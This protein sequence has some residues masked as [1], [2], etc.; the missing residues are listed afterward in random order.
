MD[1]INIHRCHKIFLEQS[2]GQTLAFR[3]NKE[4]EKAVAVLQPLFARTCCR[5]KN[6]AAGLSASKGDIIVEKS[7]VFRAQRE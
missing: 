1:M 5:M 2:N 7:G 3:E 4:L 6:S